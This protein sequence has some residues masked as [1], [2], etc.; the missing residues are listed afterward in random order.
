MR[1]RTLAIFCVL[2][3]IG[4]IGISYVL[5]LEATLGDGSGGMPVAQGR[6]LLLPFAYFLILFFCCFRFVSGAWL[7]PVGEI[8][9][10]MTLVG[11]ALAA[12][13]FGW[14]GFLLWLPFVPYAI[15]SRKLFRA[16]K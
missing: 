14:F 8:L 2:G 12:L 5:L 13:T 7:T 3:I 11:F 16:P 10:T 4:W 15:A 1:S 6:I 9:A